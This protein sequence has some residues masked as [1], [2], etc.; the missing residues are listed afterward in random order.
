MSQE[1]VELVKRVLSRLN[2]RDLDG[3][4]ADVARDAELDWSRSEALDSGVYHGHTEWRNWMFGRW[5]ELSEMSFD[6]IE[7]IDAGPD[8]VVTVTRFRGRGRASGVE[9][10]A[11][12]AALWTV[13]SGMVS[14]LSFYQSKDKALTAAGRAE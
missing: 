10:E 4:L 12:G 8:I 1:N 9:V 6:P 7:V 3:A 13:R 5:E 2:H 14:N 11:I